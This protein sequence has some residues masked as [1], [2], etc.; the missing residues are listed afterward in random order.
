MDRKE[1]IQYI[2]ILLGGSL[3]GAS[4]FLTGCKAADK[5]LFSKED[6]A[7]LDEIAETILPVTTTPGAIAAQAGQ[8]MTVMINDCYDEKERA[9][10]KKGMITLNELSSENFEGNFMKITLQ[11]RHELLVEVDNEQ[12]KYMKEKKEGEPVHYFRMMKELTL[13]GYFSSE[14]GCT[15]AKRY[16]PVPGKYIGCVDYKKGDKVIV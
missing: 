5:Q 14:P 13:L 4:I 12:K 8:F 2:S 15:K 10:F 16:M 1:A 11:Q 7:Y 3:T 6:I 9:I